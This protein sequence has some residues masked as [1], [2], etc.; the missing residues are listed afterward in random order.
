M[1]KKKQSYEEMTE[2]LNAIA[3]AMEKGQ[4][5][6]ETMVGLFEEGMD[7][8]KKCE[9]ELNVAADRV[10]VLT[11]EGEQIPWEGENDV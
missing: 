2:R 11:E 5:D 7:L 9:G 3:E 1:T 10:R 4:P 8:I 6:L